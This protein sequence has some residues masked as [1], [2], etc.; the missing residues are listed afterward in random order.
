MIVRVLTKQSII[1]QLT[2]AQSYNERG[3]GRM[4]R[5]LTKHSIMCDPA[6]QKPGS[7]YMWLPG[8]KLWSR[9]RGCHYFLT[10]YQKPKTK[11]RSVNNG[12]LEIETIRNRNGN[13]LSENNVTFLEVSLTTF[14]FRIRH[15]DTRGKS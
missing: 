11:R 12:L 5:V 4:P 10:N 8:K 14:D 13:L 9:N 15:E 1:Y 7:L 3:A 2:Q 6:Y